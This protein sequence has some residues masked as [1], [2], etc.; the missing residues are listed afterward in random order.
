MA[1]KRRGRGEGAIYQRG[2]GIWTASASLGYDAAGK[3]KRK[4]VYG[5]TK[6]E[7]QDKLQRL[8]SGTDSGVEPARFTVDQFL[9]HVARFGPGH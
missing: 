4:V 7:V 9:Q 3:R 1:R 8:Q 5:A 2:D 6:K